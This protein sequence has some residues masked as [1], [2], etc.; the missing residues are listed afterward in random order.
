MARGSTDLPLRGVAFTTEGVD[1]F[2]GSVMNIDNQDFVSKMEGFAVQGM[3]GRD[4]FFLKHLL[5]ADCLY[6]GA[7]RNH[8]K[9]VS[10]V[11]STI[12]REINR[13]LRKSI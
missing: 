10:D 5:S 3:K 11:Q 4:Y 6:S 2:M 12:R 13:T 7:A 8:K 9:L 1:E